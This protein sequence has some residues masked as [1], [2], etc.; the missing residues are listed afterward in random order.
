MGDR[1][2]EAWALQHLA[3]I[4]FVDG[5]ADEAVDR[6]TR[7]ADTFAEIG[8]VGGL[9]WAFGLLAYVCYIQGD[10]ARAD[11]LGQ[12]VL[13]EARERGDRWGEGM[14]LQLAAGVRCWSGH[15]AEALE[16]ARESHALFATIGDRFGQAQSL[17]TL[18]RALVALGRVGEGITILSDALDDSLGDPDSKDRTTLVTGLAAAAVAIGDPEVALEAFDRVRDV[19]L[20]GMGV[21][22]GAGALER[23]VAH[24]LAHLQAG[25]LDEAV[26]QLRPMVDSDPVTASPYAVA[27]LALALVVAGDDAAAVELG[28]LVGTDPRATYMDRAVASMALA[29]A[30]A[31][32]GDADAAD[33]LAVAVAAVDGTDDVV[34]RAVMQLAFASVLL[35]LGR[36]DAT[37][38]RDAAE[39]SLGELGLDATGW[40]TVMR[41]A[42]DS[43]PASV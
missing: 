33:H 15:T 14:M 38:A 29:L 22:L 41:L 34:A 40:R 21:G 4:S 42:L 36:D 31:R 30:Q 16:Y 37:A 26:D 17:T 18:G 19:D 2:G 8:D 10:L 24:A 9:G 39:L 28:G 12:Q 11:E 43:S 13:V 27:S 23:D 3:W 6:L 35:E 20:S 25:Q 1:R 5:R 7:A 32:A